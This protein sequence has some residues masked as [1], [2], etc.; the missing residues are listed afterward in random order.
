LIRRVLVGLLLIAGVVGLRVDSA[1]GCEF[2]TD[3]EPGSR[4]LKSGGF[5]G[6]CAGGLFPGNTHD[7][8]PVED[9]LDPNGTVGNTCRFSAADCGPGNFCLKKPGAI[10][11]VC[12]RKGTDLLER[13]R[14]PR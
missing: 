13:K 2:S 12:V 1:H 10:E 5:Y 9:P 4:C 14:K 7:R 11:G 8:V 3:C 6:V